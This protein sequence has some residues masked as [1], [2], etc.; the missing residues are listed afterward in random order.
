MATFVLVFDGQEIEIYASPHEAVKW[1]K[2]ML[3][4]GE[5]GVLTGPEFEKELAGR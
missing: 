3:D 1:A 5:V 2:W 4:E